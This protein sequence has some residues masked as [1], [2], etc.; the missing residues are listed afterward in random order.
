M[1]RNILLGIGLAVFITSA[2]I[3]M[4]PFIGSLAP[5]D[6]STGPPGGGGGCGSPCH[7]NYDSSCIYRPAPPNVGPGCCCKNISETECVTICW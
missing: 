4:T 6:C 7:C 1:V 2:A 3:S 5:Y